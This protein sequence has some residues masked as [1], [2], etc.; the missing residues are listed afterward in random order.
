MIAMNE[1]LKFRQTQE[2]NAAKFST[3][4]LIV[5]ML[6]MA[7]WGWTPLKNIV[8]AAANLVF[9]GILMLTSVFFA[10]TSVYRGIQKR[11]LKAKIEDEA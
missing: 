9:F 1:E 5:A 8:P 7:A 4:C 6:M 10:L 11:S 2:R 3:A